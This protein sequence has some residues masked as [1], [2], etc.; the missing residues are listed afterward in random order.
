MEDVVMGTVSASPDIQVTPTASSAAG[1]I[2]M[3]TVSATPDILATATASA[4]ASASSAA[5][6][7]VMGTVTTM[8]DIPIAIAPSGESTSSSTTMLTPSM[9]DDS[10]NP[11]VAAESLVLN[12]AAN[13]PAWMV[14]AAEYLL[15]I[16]GQGKEWEVLVRN[17]MEIERV[18]N[19]PDGAVRV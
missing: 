15:A 18:L 1:N 17:W 4:S 5:D 9:A 6:D 8:P 3:G 19:Y 11:E 13:D 2:V 14:G 16:G 12:T 10:T 7:V